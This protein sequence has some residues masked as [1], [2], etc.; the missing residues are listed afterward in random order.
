MIQ[1]RRESVVLRSHFRIV[2]KRFGEET[3]IFD[4]AESIADE[5]DDSIHCDDTGE[6][7]KKYRVVLV[8]LVGLY[9]LRVVDNCCYVA[10]TNSGRVNFPL[11]EQR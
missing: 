7:S 6:N 1:R 10:R 5:L 9:W 2:K 4:R 8:D 11:P 3:E